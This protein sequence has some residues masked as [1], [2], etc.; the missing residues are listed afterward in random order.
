MHPILAKYLFYYPVT[1]LNG[2]HIAGYLREYSDFQW[3]PSPTIQNIQSANT[4][5]ILDYAKQHSS[6]YA[7]LLRNIDIN[8]DFQRIPFLTKQILIKQFNNICTAERKNASLKT[9]GGSTGEPVKLYKNS[10]ALARERAATW[11][12]YAWAG[13]TIG[14]KQARFW[15]VPHNAKDAKKAELIDFISNRKR[16]SAFNLTTDSLNDY[17]KTLLKFK[18]RYLYGYVSVIRRF[19]EHLA[20]NDLSPLPSVQSIITTSEILSES[21][22]VFIES[23][24]KVKVYNEYGCGEVGSI[25]HECE[26][27]NMHIMADNMLVEILDSNGNPASSG[28]VVVTDFFNRATPL[29]RYRLGD[30]ASISHESCA[31]GRTLPILKG[32]HGRAYD[33]IKT[34]SGKSVHPEALIYVFEELQ[35]KHQAFSQFQIIQTAVDRLDINII[36]TKSWTEN[37][38]TLIMEKIHEKI[39]PTFSGTFIIREEI[40]REKSGKMRVVKSLI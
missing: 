14:D 31:C 19:C 11:R 21:D 27:G 15:G 22:R 13:V 32:I 5:K 17:Y 3:L 29:I 24:C 40:P 26:H 1:L 6:Y 16:V 20:A 25:A 10:D 7:E 33:I 38:Q 9:T 8:S 35:Q 39:D 36:P 34:Q 2:E 28:E 37:F 4:A 18:P 23:V 30:F 12:A